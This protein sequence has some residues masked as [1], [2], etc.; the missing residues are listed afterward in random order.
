MELTMI[1][2]RHAVNI[3]E[4]VAP[5]EAEQAEHRQ[6]DTHTETRR[7]FHIEGV[8][9]LEPKPAVTGFEEGQGIDSGLRIQRE[10]IT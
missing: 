6:I 2:A 4:A 1:V 10:R 7:A 9:V 8:E 3:I 5:V